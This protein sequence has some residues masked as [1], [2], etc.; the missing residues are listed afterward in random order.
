DLWAAD[1]TART[2][3]LI[4]SDSSVQRLVGSEVEALDRFGTTDVLHDNGIWMP[5]NHRLAMLAARRNIARVV[6]I[7]GMLEP[8]AL[9]DKRWKKR[10]AWWLYQCSD[11][12]RARCLHL[13]AAAEARNVEVLGLGVPVSVIPNGVDVPE[14]PSQTAGARNANKTGPRVKTALFLGRIHPKKGLPLLIEAWARVRP[15][16]WILKIA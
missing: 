14:L 11:L 1:Q 4:S 12:K 6:S 16:N 9:N 15:N 2:T 3:P 13:T 8:W 10:C 7:R 5:H